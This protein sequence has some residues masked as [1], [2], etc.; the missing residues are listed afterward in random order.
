[1]KNLSPDDAYAMLFL[2]GVC[3]VIG[4]LIGFL[5]GRLWEIGKQKDKELENDD[6]LA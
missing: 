3:A 1:M 4:G 5:C 6:R 2:M